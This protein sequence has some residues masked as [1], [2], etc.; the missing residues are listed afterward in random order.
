MKKKRREPRDGK[1]KKRYVREVGNFTAT[2][3]CRGS[4]LATRTSPS[5]FTSKYKQMRY[6]RV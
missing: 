2:K 3:I 6:L 5:G 1:K 4:K